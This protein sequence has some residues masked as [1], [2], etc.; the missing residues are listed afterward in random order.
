MGN[1]SQRIGL[2]Q[3]TPLMGPMSATMGFNSQGMVLMQQTP[4]SNQVNFELI[5]CW[6]FHQ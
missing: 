1:N 5:S 3:R 6:P 4:E 2:M